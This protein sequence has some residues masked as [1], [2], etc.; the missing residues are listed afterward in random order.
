[1][2]IPLI[3]NFIIS[4]KK[5]IDSR[6]AVANATERNAIPTAYRWDG[7]DVFQRDDRKTYTW[8]DVTQAWTTVTDFSLGTGVL[9]SIT[10]WNSTTTIGS[11]FMYLKPVTGSNGYIGINTNNPKSELQISS[12]GG[13]GVPMYFGSNSGGNTISDNYVNG[14]AIDNTS[15]GSSNIYSNNGIV[16]ISTRAPGGS[17]S[18][19]NRLNIG[20]TDFNTYGVHGINSLVDLGTAPNAFVKLST[21]KTSVGNVGYVNEFALRSSTG[22]NTWTTYLQHNGISIDSSFLTPGTTRTFW[23]RDPYNNFHYFGSTANY[24]LTIDGGNN[25]IGVNTKTPTQAIDVLGNYGA[26]NGPIIKL[27]NTN[28]V[29]P[30]FRPA[31][32][33]G[34]ICKN[35]NTTSAVFVGQR[36]FTTVNDY[37]VF[38]VNMI[39]TGA[40]LLKLN[41]NGQMVLGSLTTTSNASKMVVTDSNLELYQQSIPEMMSS[42]TYLATTSQNGLMPKELVSSLSTVVKSQVIYLSSWAKDRKY[43]LAHGLS[44]YT[45]IIS[46]IVTMEAKV[47]DNGY[48][49]GDITTSQSRGQDQDG[50]NDYD[51]GIGAR[52]RVNGLSTI[53]VFCGD[54]IFLAYGPTDTATNND[55]F[56]VDPS[57]WYIRL[58][59][60]YI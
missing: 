33:A 21:I 50:S 24:T 25:R 30:G 27:E 51:Y 31:Y 14:G 7:M 5:P 29:Y 28:A 4:V 22:G 8:N 20:Y 59:I 60:L 3:D 40:A 12:N 36:P 56:N 13:S 34:M 39:S 19:I 52:W 32:G 2:A 1:M 44:G 10:F 46:V 9:N 18:L 17:T 43:T 57:K 49:A 48:I 41:K 37:E 47:N 42:S 11:S 55:A 26:G 35:I 54:R 58:V 38:S 6:R 53:S 16:G 23:E 45:S 15:R